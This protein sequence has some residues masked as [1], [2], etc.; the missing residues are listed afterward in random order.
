MVHMQNREQRHLENR[1]L[2]RSNAR[3]CFPFIATPPPANT[4]FPIRGR[5]KKPREEIV[6]EEIV[7]GSEGQVRK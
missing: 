5:K 4:N 6:R 2:S 1:Q 7:G 3:H